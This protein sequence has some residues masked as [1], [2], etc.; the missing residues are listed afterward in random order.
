MKKDAK[1]GEKAE[2]GFIILR[3]MQLTM[4]SINDITF[5]NKFADICGI[6]EEELYSNFKPGIGELAGEY[7][8]SYE[9]ACERLKKTMT[10]IVLHR[11]GARSI[12][13]GQS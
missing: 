3:Y 2:Y 10:A 8:I 7:N 12:I 4:E 9:T 13:R 1:I 11:K 6:T 5:D